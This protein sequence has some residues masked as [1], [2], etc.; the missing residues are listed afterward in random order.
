[1]S[2]ETAISTKATPTYPP[3]PIFNTDPLTPEQWTTLVAIT[4]AIIPAI[5]SNEPATSTT[6][7]AVSSAEFE[8]ALQ[9]VKASSGAN[10]E[11]ARAYLE[12]SVSQVPGFQDSL[13]RRLGQYLHGQGQKDIS[14]ILNALK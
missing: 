14:F 13:R 12:E 5:R 2:L 10:D 4:D 1:M 11:D 8:D 6:A 3:L 9:K 7:L